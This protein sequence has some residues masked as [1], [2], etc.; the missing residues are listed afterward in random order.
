VGRR[1][2]AKRFAFRRGNIILKAY[3]HR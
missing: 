2:T 3:D 1:Q